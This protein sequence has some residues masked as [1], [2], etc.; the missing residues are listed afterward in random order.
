V[1]PRS[2]GDKGQPITRKAKVS[3][4]GSQKWKE[5]LD[6]QISVTV[7]SSES[8]DDR[9]DHVVPRLRSSANSPRDL[10]IPDDL[11]RLARLRG[12]VRRR[13]KRTLLRRLRLLREM[14]R[15]R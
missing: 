6:V 9:R 3:F 14:R 10:A 11:R 2:K 13:L 5:T 8:S 4:K 7:V 12:L 15:L 1:G